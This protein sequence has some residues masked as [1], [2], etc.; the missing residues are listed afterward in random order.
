M[1]S[2][3]SAKTLRRSVHPISQLCK[4]VRAFAN[5]N[6]K[7]RDF[8]SIRTDV[9]EALSSIGIEHDTPV[10][11]RCR[12]PLLAGKNT[13]LAAETG[14]GKTLAYLAPLMSRSL[15]T[16]QEWTMKQINM[17][18]QESNT[19]VV[20]CPNEVLCEQVLQAAQSI[21]HRLTNISPAF[22]AAA[23]HNAS[24][25]DADVI[26]TTPK[27]FQRDLAQKNNSKNY[28][29]GWV[30][31]AIVFDEADMLLD[32]SFVDD[33]I[34]IIKNARNAGVQLVFAA[35]TMPS[36]G[37]KT[38]GKLIEWHVPDTT[39]V[40]GDRLHR[41]VANLQHEWIDIEEYIGNNGQVS[42]DSDALE[43]ARLRLLER[44]LHTSEKTM[45]F[46]NTANSAQRVAEQLQHAVPAPVSAYHKKVHPTAARRTLH[47]FAH[48]NTGV[49][50][51]TD[52][53]SRGIDIPSI[54]TVVQAE[55]A[56]SAVDFLHRAGRTARAGGGGKVVSLYATPERALAERAQ[57]ALS[58]DERLEDVFS[59]QRAFRRRMKRYGNPSLPE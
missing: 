1:R 29:S 55:F 23:L 48:T 40:E 47:W 2:S 35:A 11:A 25:Q 22:N 42:S 45:V 34:A 16:K 9:Q 18:H 7:Q 15:N 58:S 59:R 14:S 33:S 27:R 21:A 30:P 31:Q 38:P 12:A 19:I 44:L 50:V 46:C 49:L 20:L 37:K 32:G 4:S 3:A 8:Q 6:T 53:A 26:A 5:G 57:A 24:V 51:S 28:N 17:V 43:A 52:A 13:V 36:F 41:S 54:T 39:W 10:Q 56:K